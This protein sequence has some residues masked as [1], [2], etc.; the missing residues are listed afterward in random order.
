MGPSD[1]VVHLGTVDRDVTRRVDGEAHPIVLYRHD[2]DAYAVADHDGL[3]HLSGQSQQWKP[4][5]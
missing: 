4:P 1:G 3:A 2:R 5:F